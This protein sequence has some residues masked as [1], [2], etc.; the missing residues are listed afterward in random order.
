MWCNEHD[1]A[2][3]LNYYR[4]DQVHQVSQTEETNSEEKY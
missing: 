4:Y 2:L 1:Y 3:I